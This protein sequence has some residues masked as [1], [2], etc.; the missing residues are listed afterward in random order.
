MIPLIIHTMVLVA[1]VAG[2]DIEFRADD[3][4]DTRPFC[5][6]VKFNGAVEV[7]VIGERQRIHARL[8]RVA[9]QIIYFGESV[10]QAIMRMDMQMRKFHIGNDT[11]GRGVCNDPA[12]I[13]GIDEAGRGPL[14]GPVVVAGVKIH[15]AL[16]R[17]L[18]VGIRDSKKLSVRKR[19]AWYRLLTRHPAV[20]WAVARVSPAVIDRINISAAGNLGASRVYRR[21]CPKLSLGQRALL[22]AGLK[23]PPSIAQRTIIKGDEKISAIAAASIIAKVT[24]DRLMRRLHNQYPQ[25]RFDLHKGYGTALHRAMIQKYGRCEMHRQS[26]KI[27][28]H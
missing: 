3:G 13:I 21:L 10:Q 24:R 27:V 1:H 9:H 15:P 8:S 28:L 4:F 2:R 19:E 22:D 7:A 11:T 26:F 5:F 17:R 12:A 14:A 20:Q 18:L 6:L 16:A 23:L 25:Y